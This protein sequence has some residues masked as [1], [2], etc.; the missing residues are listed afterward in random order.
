MPRGR[1]RQFSRKAFETFNGFEIVRDAVVDI[2]NSAERLL[3]HGFSGIFSKRCYLDVDIVNSA[4]RLLRRPGVVF[5][6]EGDL[7]RVDIVNSAERLLRLDVTLN[8]KYPGPS[9]YRQF[10]RKA[11]ETRSTSRARVPR[12]SLSISSIQPKGF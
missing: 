4:E 12:L 10:S 5:I 3:R 7:D 6:P 1:Y 8:L 9:R 2:V 11:F